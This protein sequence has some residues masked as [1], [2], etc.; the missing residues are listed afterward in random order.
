MLHVVNW[1]TAE[2][3]MSVVSAV[4]LVMLA[5]I[6]GS[7]A[8]R[9]YVCGSAYA[10]FCDD[11]LDKNHYNVRLVSCLASYNACWR[12]EGWARCKNANT[13]SLACITQTVADL[14]FREEGL[15]MDG[16]LLFSSPSLFPSHVLPPV[17][18][19]SLLFPLFP[20]ASSFPSCLCRERNP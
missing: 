15:A 10:D 4:V 14:G 8:I 3:K 2:Q 5:F 12:G 7:S 9:C 13:L 16:S 19:F 1:L 6:H 11:P 20:F 18:M 17:L